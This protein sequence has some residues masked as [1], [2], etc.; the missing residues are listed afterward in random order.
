[1]HRTVTPY[2]QAPARAR[3]KLAYGNPRKAAWSILGGLGLVV[4]TL[5]F[6]GLSLLTR[7]HFFGSVTYPAFFGVLLLV[8]ARWGTMELWRDRGV[9]RIA[10]RGLWPWKGQEVPLPEVQTVEVVPSSM[11]ERK[12]DFV[13]NLVMAGDRR[14]PLLRG[15]TMEALEGDR[16]AIAAF[17]EDNGLLWGGRVEEPKE[18][19]RVAEEGEG[20][21]EGEEA[22]TQERRRHQGL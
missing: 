4:L 14:I 6:I 5:G 22:A 17:L 1:M 3:P 21:A 10:R 7:G 2:R 19:V 12:P 11:R 9:L 13:L 8:R 15:G 18:R 20:V 16:S